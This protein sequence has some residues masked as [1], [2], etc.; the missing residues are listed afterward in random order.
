MSFSIVEHFSE[1]KDF[2]IERKK[3]HALPDIL[4]LSVCAVISGA[5]GWEDVA[6]FRALIRNASVNVLY[7]G[8]KG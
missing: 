2:R 3:L 7:G 8:L 6:E 1:L 5:E 4:V